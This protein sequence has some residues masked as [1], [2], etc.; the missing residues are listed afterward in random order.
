MTTQKTP[1]KSS[2]S[3]IKE[4][5]GSICKCVNGDL[6][7]RFNKRKI[8]IDLNEQLNW[9][10]AQ[11][12]SNEAEYIGGSLDSSLVHEYAP[13]VGTILERLWEFDKTPE[14]LKVEQTNK[15]IDDALLEAQQTVDATG[16]RI[17]DEYAM[18]IISSEDI[19]D[20][21]EELKKM[22]EKF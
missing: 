17:V 20:R 8:E 10:L 19:P 7:T 4:R 15:N 18:G 13:K 6:V 1:I 22:S 12:Q 16:M 5:V 11:I 14:Q 3:Y 2:I 21:L 9:M